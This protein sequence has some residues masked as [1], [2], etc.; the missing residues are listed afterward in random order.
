M[1]QLLKLKESWLFSVS[2]GP[3]NNAMHLSRHLTLINVLCSSLRPGDGQRSKD[4]LSLMGAGKA[5]LHGRSQE[6]TVVVWLK[7]ARQSGSSD[8]LRVSVI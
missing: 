6:A 4:V 3:H 7:S 8:G 2:I 5:A 1:P